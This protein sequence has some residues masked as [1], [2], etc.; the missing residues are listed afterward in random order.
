[1]QKKYLLAPGPTAVPPEILLAMAHP[2][3]HHRSKDFEPIV[4]SVKEDLKWL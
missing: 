4:A 2:M 3:V 1:M